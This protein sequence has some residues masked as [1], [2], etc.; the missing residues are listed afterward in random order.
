MQDDTDEIWVFGY[1]S[2]MW[3][4]GFPHLEVHPALLRGYHR[5][6]CV[7]S[8]VFRGT[9]E[10]PGLV[11]GLNRGGACRGRAYRVAAGD[12]KAALDQLDARELVH[13][14]YIRRRA[15]VAI[16]N[17]RRVAAWFYVAR[18]DHEQYAG[19]LSPEEIAR[20]VATRSG[21]EGSSL[22]Y[23]RNT[24]AHMDDMGIADGPLHKVL[25]M[26]EEG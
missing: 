17:G 25:E 6:L 11:T 14:V 9:P 12:A 3:R 10:A 21:P 18:P 5:A 22:E 8:V 20:L 15:P 4:P 24:V 16:K 7:Y 2:L 1:G 13:G 23:L 26:A 19:N